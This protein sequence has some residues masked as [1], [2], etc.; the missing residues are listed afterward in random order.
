[1]SVRLLGATMDA[2]I[3]AGLVIALDAALQEAKSATTFANVLRIHLPA[4]RESETF[5]DMAGD[6][7]SIADTIDNISSLVRTMTKETY[8][9]MD[10]L[11]AEDAVYARESIENA[12]GQLKDM[13][14]GAKPYLFGTDK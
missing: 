3:K 14:D 10:E 13:I 6:I 9:R 7:A 1:M 12:L 8:V 5:A 11:T 4:I 2:I